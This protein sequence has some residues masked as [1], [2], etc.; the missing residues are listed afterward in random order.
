MFHEHHHKAEERRKR[1]CVGGGTRAVR[2]SGVEVAGGERCDEEDGKG[3]G[4]AV[5]ESGVEEA[6][7]ERCDEKDGKGWGKAVRV[8]VHGDKLV[9]GEVGFLDA[10]RCFAGIRCRPLASAEVFDVSDP[11]APALLSELTAAAA[12]AFFD[13]YEGARR[14]RRGQHTVE[15]WESEEV[16]P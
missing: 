6:G 3:W 14:V 13:E 10:F 5:Q 7:G 4:K 8:T 15:V 12:E 1:I 9:V 11:A 16:S 2:E